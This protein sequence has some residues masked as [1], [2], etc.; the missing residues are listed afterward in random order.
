MNK[1]KELRF[2]NTMAVNPVLLFNSYIQMK[3]VTN[4]SLV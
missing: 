3:E 2:T 4:P 1:Q